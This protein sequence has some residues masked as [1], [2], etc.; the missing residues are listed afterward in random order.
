MTDEMK[1]KVWTVL[2]DECGA[3]PDG[4]SD[5]LAHWPECHE[6][7]FIGS[8]GFGGKVWADRFYDGWRLSVTCYSED[9]TPERERAIGRAQSRLTAIE[10]AST[11]PTTPA[12]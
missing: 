8:L 9:K 5:F 11:R 3:D 7:R 1:R 2:V 6:Y 4:L 10:V 12:S